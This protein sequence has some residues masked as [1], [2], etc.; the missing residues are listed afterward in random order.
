MVSSGLFVGVLLVLVRPRVCFSSLLLMF[1]SA[2]L[3]RPI[4]GRLRYSA[5]WKRFGSTFHS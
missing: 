2:P 3:Q 5:H 1:L 4:V